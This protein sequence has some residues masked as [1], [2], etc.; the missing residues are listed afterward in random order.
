MVSGAKVFKLGL[1]RV[2]FFLTPENQVIIN[3]LNTMPG[4][5][6]TSVFPMLWKA[7][8]KSYSEVISQLCVSAL[9]RSR[10]VVR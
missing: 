8:G 10:N 9:S 3:E 5:T 7:S 6:S 2:D 1:A 4:F